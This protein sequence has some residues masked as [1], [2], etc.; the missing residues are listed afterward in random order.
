M[1]QTVDAEMA[2]MIRA[3]WERNQDQVIQRLR[4]LDRAAAEN[5]QGHMGEELRHEAREIAHKLAGSLGIFGF[6]SGGAIARRMEQL[7][8]SGD[9]D[10]ELLLELAQ[11][12]RG[13]L[14]SQA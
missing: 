8:E 1:T 3:L 6:P 12:L 2:R 4:L 7:F 14:F 9:P 11:Q 13:S 10:P 5:R